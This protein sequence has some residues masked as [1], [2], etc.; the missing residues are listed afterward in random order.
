ML[1][2]AILGL[3]R[4]GAVLVDAVQG[5]SETIRFTR[6]VVRQPAKYAALARRHGFDLGSD[7]DAVLADPTV[8][9][10]VLA[11]PHSQHV[12]QVIHAARAGKHV[13]CDKPFATDLAGARRA[14]AAADSAG[15]VLAIGFQ[16]RF[17]PAYAEL[18]RRIE[19]GAL[20]DP[21]H[22][23]ANQSAPAGLRL[24]AENWRAQPGE[25]RGGAMGGHGIHMVDMMIG[26]FGPVARVAAW[27]RKH[28]A[29]A[30]FD[31]STLAMLDFA[32]GRTGTLTSV[33]VTAPVHRI[34]V[35]GT[36]GW[37]QISD[38]RLFEYRPLAG[39]VE[40]IEFPE[41]KIER[42]ELE[43]FAA[44][45]AGKAPFV[46]SRAEALHGQAVFDAIAEAT[47]HGGVVDVP[48]TD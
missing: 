20:G 5:R 34:T 27:A 44:A 16:R 12:E 14:Q 47:E 18:K 26:L 38:H 17:L 39:P 45:V 28:H 2:A 4:W 23:E 41:A 15:V 9:A 40:R 25:M 36:K 43:A 10:V 6:A 19:A 8:K 24:G 3:G 33:L 11:T 46:V 7:Y 21:V 35:M 29:G 13:L 1:D 42:I 32:N 22:V 30:V 31:D 37:A 48:A